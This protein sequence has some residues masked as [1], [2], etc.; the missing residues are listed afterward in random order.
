MDSANNVI[1][2]RVERHAEAAEETLADLNVRVTDMPAAGSRDRQLLERNLG[3]LEFEIVAAEAKLEAA[4]AEEKGDAH[5]FAQATSRAM[6][7]QRSALRAEIANDPHG[8]ASS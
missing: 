4:R 8:Q 1:Q 5:G 3:S 7:A 6:S 2:F